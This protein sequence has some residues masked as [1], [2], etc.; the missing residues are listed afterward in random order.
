VIVRDAALGIWVATSAAAVGAV[1]GDERFRV[2]PLDEPVPAALVGTPAGAIFARMARMNEGERHRHL[3]HIATALVDP[4]ALERLG[5][6]AAQ[7]TETVL[8]QRGRADA[9]AVDRAAV[10]G[11]PTSVAA[12]L[13]ARPCDPTEFAGDVDAF[14]RAFAPDPDAQAVARASA[15]VERL[16]ARLRPAVGSDDDRLANAVG[17][18][19]QVHPA[20]ATLIRATLLALARH[21]AWQPAFTRDAAT[22]LRVMREVARL[23]APVQHTRR[24]LAED[25]TVAGAALRAGDVVR[26]AIATANRD[27]AVNPDPERFDPDRTNPT[28][29]SFGAGRH[30]C[31]GERIATTIAASVV[32]HLVR[33]GTVNP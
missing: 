13:G 24:F 20:T 5:A 14:A 4:F 15:A 9:T 7:V 23:D 33:A 27:P 32:T 1:L 21:P 12:L 18:F 16:R 17:F 22:A 2:R 29:F 31:I 19:F 11:P 10:E 26:V 25:A 30:A 8:R 6:E 28:S 3:R